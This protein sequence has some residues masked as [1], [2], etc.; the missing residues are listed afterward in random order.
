MRSDIDAEHVVVIGAPSSRGH[1]YDVRGKD[2][3][4]EV[5]LFYYFFFRL[6]FISSGLLV[7]IYEALDAWKCID[8]I[9]LG[10]G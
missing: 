9:I 4:L 1:L 10:D 5:E 7:P 3:A 6:P 8:R 2:E